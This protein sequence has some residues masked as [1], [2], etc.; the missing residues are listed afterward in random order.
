L[1][2][3]KSRASYPEGIGANARKTGCST[4][5]RMPYRPSRHQKTDYRRSAARAIVFATATEPPP[6]GGAAPMTVIERI[7]SDE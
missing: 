6:G 2:P 7:A 3:I 5:R 1:R 4:G